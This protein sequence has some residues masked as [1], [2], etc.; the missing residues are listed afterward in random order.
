[1]TTVTSLPT[2]EEE[3][4]EEELVEEELVEEELAE[5]ELVEGKMHETDGG[6]VVVVVVVV[7]ARRGRGEGRPSS[8]VPLTG[9]AKALAVQAGVGLAAAGV[10]VAIIQLIQAGGCWDTA[11]NQRIDPSTQRTGPPPRTP[12][13]PSPTAE[14]PA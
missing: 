1:V 3:L 8:R 4:V 12:A 9:D 11:V 2:V 14:A 5:E 10:V 7:V 13:P 6:V